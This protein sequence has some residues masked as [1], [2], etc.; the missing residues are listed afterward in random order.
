MAIWHEQKPNC[1]VIHID[2][3][4]LSEDIVDRI[5]QIL[6]VAFLNQSYKLIFDMSSCTMIDSYFIGLLISTY[7][8]VRDL[9]GTITCV[10]LTGQVAHAFEAVRLNQLVSVYDTLSEALKDIDV[11]PISEPTDEELLS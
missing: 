4:N 11:P 8:E 9:G 1:F 5:R 2:E 7:R 6:T 3:S 10:G